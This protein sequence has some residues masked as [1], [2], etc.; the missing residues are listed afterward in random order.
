MI[1]NIWTYSAVGILIVG[2][3]IMTLPHKN[4]FFHDQP[5]VAAKKAL[6]AFLNQPADDISC[7]LLTASEEAIIVKCTHQVTSYIV[8]LFSTSQSGENEIAW[9]RH[10]SDLGIGPKL[11]YADSTGNYML[12]EFAKGNSLVPATANTPA[13]IKSIATSVARLHHS[14]A[15]FAHES[16]MFARIDTKYK[17][18]NCSG[19]LKDMSE[20]DLQQ[21][22]KIETQ[23][24][25]L[26]I[27]PVPCHNDLNWGNIFA[28]NNRVTLIDW[29]DAAPGN[30]YYDIAAFFVLNVIEKENEKLFFEQYDGKLLS[31]EWQAYMQLYKQLVYF[32]FA[33]N[34]LLGVQARKSELLH[35]QD[36]TQVNHINYYLTL[37]AE[38]EVEIDSAFLYNMAIASLKKMASGF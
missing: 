26:E 13:I 5:S 31:A 36:I 16:D 34:L 37:L 21:V 11:Y 4:S 29:G 7:K 17:K 32:E 12:I 30:P 18:L 19:I 9:T 22:K 38:Q 10:A 23:L 3:I 20:N 27:S 15:P 33:L 25:S 2:I 1:H 35:A 6:A 8:K 28:S 24:Q 14:S